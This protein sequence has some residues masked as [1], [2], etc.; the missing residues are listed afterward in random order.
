M[1]CHRL[2]DRTCVP[3]ASKVAN[4]QVSDEGAVDYPLLRVAQLIRKRGEKRRDETRREER[5]I[6]N[7]G[8]YNVFAN[9]FRTLFSPHGL[10]S[11]Q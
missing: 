9:C 8:H 1:V 3:S 10:S 11:V 7:E 4:E 5:V 6:Q 2:M